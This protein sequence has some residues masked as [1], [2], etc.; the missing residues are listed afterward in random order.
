M[1]FILEHD[2]AKIETLR[3]QNSSSRLTFSNL[4]TLPNVGGSV[5]NDVDYEDT[6]G[7]HISL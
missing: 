7:N 2:P 3:M 5:F 6:S 1:I 4:W